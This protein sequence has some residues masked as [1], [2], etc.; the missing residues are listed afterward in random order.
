MES[1]NLV[2]NSLVYLNQWDDHVDVSNDNWSP[3]KFVSIVIP[4]WNP[5]HKLDLTLASLAG[6]SYP[7]DLFEVLIVDDGNQ[8]PYS[9]PAL[10]PKNTKVINVASGWGR[11]NALNHG[12]AEARGDIYFCLD[13]D[14]ICHRDHISENARIYDQ[15]SYAIVKNDIIFVDEWS[16]SQ[17]EVLEAVQH[18]KLGDVI[19]TAGVRAAW[20][21]ARFSRSERLTKYSNDIFGFYTGGSCSMPRELFERIGGFDG[22]LKL[23]E[24]IEVGFRLMEAGAVLVPVRTAAG[25]HLGPA[26]SQVRAEDV[27]NFNDHYFAQRIPMFQGRRRNKQSGWE[28]PFVVVRLLATDN[29]A[30][31][32]RELVN[33]ILNGTQKDVSVQVLGPWDELELGRR[34]PLGD[35]VNMYL[36]HEWF[37]GDQR[38]KFL[39]HQDENLP[40]FPTPYLIDFADL[41]L[42]IDDDAIER[43][44]GEVSRRKIGLMELPVLTEQKVEEQVIRVTRTA[45]HERL[46]RLGMT[47]SEMNKAAYS[48]VSQVWVEAPST[49]GVWTTR[50]ELS[51][52]SKAKAQIKKQESAANSH[53]G[54]AVQSVQTQQSSQLTLPNGIKANLKLSKR[55]FRRASRLMLIRL[56][57]KF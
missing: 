44:I 10:S 34:S 27:N 13:A 22:S 8:I 48:K 17:L 43:I 33:L 41:V 28:I 19:N 5:D 47:E 57:I 55:A 26:T 1:K 42:A 7:E 9:I 6:Q 46:L 49:F 16:G 2:K 24:D 36:L 21:E 37:R 39:D 31:E 45:F 35:Q 54:A 29:N 38:V 56:N 30:A 14:I 25:Y 12:F 4:A 53:P 20:L 23:G 50:D 51:A 52:F 3:T 11:A 32:I 40:V 15:I 18:D